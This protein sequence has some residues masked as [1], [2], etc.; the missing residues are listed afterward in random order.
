MIR[1]TRRL[2]IL[3]PLVLAV[4]CGKPEPQKAVAPKA[5]A[6]KAAAPDEAVAVKD[7]FDTDETG[8][9]VPKPKTKEE[10]AA[11]R[12]AYSPFA[13]KTYPTH[14]YFGDT[15]HHT[16]NSGD[17]MMAGNTLSPEQAYRFARGEEVV[18]STGIPVK[19]SRPLDFLVVSDH[20]EGLGLMF[21]VAQ[22][23]PAF[24]SD[25]LAARWSKVLRSGTPE[26]KATTQNEVSKAQAEGTLPP[27]FKDPKV[28]GPVMKSVWTE[29]T[30]TA[31]KFN[32]PGRFTAMIG[33]EW[34]SVPGGN[35]LHRNVIFRDNKDKADQ[36]FPFSA[37]NSEDPEKLWEWM[38]NW[39]AKT[40]GKL[41]DIAHNA[42]LSNGRMFEL[43]D[44]GGN[45]LSKDYAEKRARYEVL[46]EIVQTKGNSETH[47]MMSPNDEFAGDM[48][49]AGWE[50]GNL[51]LTDKPLS[52][53]MMP[54]NYLRG[55]LL[56]GLEQEAKLGTNP[57]KFGFVGSTDV[58]N[59]LTAIEEDNFFGKL[60]I[61]EPNAKRWEHKSKESSWD[62]KLGPVRTRYT[63]Q[64]L[65]AGYA[66]VWATEN[67]RAALW[68]A[69]KRREVYGT[70]GSRLTLRFFGGWG[71][72]GGDA[73]SR[74]LAETGYEK[75][76]PMG[77]DLKA[78]PAGAK[79]PTFLVA[80]AKDPRG[81]NLDRI[82]I[83]KGWLDKNGKG[84]EKVYD[85]AWGDADRRKVKGGKLQPVGSTVDVATATW[86]NTIGDPEL[87][88]VWTDPDFDPSVRA[89]YY[90]RTIEIPTP[91]WTAYDAVRFGV[92]MPPEVP[93]TV[94][95]RA[96]S[97]PIWY[98]PAP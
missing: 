20:A 65:A 30:A 69:M 71:F 50:Y 12:K 34:T 4:A 47:P 77:G 55:G 1:A 26:E 41:L 63:W 24:T 68:D 72:T 88:T 91:R 85:V 40:G 38:A 58:H 13:G 76:V 29:Y 94:Q 44:F 49:V 90:A 86:T 15:H 42:N 6:A 9:F 95:E 70:S 32:E 54:T 43:V 92:K 35:N 74:F 57:F 82:Q 78:A 64:Y 27:V 60:P 10:L 89:F 59:S 84:Q 96:W 79:A 5:E 25:P 52:K 7:A 45:P 3:L 37:W 93:M 66:A 67:T 73:K 19:L 75:G 39:E 36:V 53:E 98:T 17:A 23:N 83:V 21:Q 51:T 11:A 62:A 22:G 48:G 87:S 28:V 18:S 14:V 31:E 8:G 61:Q 2:A 46:Q 16:A 97:S 33:Y 81:G 80:A 56:R